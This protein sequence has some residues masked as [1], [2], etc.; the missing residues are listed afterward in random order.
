MESDMTPIQK[1]PGVLAEIKGEVT[2]EAVHCVVQNMRNNLHQY[3]TYL[4]GETWLLSRRVIDWVD[5][6]LQRLRETDLKGAKAEDLDALCRDFI[7]KLVFQEVESNRQQFTDH[8]IRHIINGIEIQQT[9][10]NQLAESG[11]PI[12]DMDRFMGIFTVI[13]N[14]VGLTTPLIR[15]G[16]LRALKCAQ[17]HAE[18]GAKILEEQRDKWDVGK[19][20]TAEQYDRIVELVKTHDAVDLSS[21]D[22]LAFATRLADNLSIFAPEKLPSVF[23]H[24]PSVRAPLLDMADAAEANDTVRFEMSREFLYQKIDVI[25]KLDDNLKRDLKAATREIIFMTPKVDMGGLAGRIIDISSLIDISSS[26]SA[27]VVTVQYNE[28]DAFLGKVF[29]MGQE[30]LKKLLGYHG[31]TD[32]SKDRYFLG[33]TEDG[34]NLVEIRVEDAPKYVVSAL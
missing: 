1:I 20:F 28:F 15:A 19:I 34:R 21:K 23:E 4:A 13:N 29:D 27:L 7:S 2:P 31:I 16:G 9:I 14:D 10:L 24:V 12:T 8:G 33:K 30:Q 5:K 25:N 17:M 18:W 6:L 26:P 22:P 32:F 11:L 3:T